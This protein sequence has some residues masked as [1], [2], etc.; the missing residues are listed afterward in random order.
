MTDVISLRLKEHEKMHIRRLAQQM[1]KDKSTATRELIEYGWRYV[2]LDA[3]KQGKISIGKASKELE[4][5]I[6]EFIDLLA[7][8]GIRSPITYEEY[9]EGEG[10]LKKV[11]KF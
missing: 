4:I 5:S 1:K 11:F 7:D 9:L 2:I 10:N 6:S 8:F 3:Y